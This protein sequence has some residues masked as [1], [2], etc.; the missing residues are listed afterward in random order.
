MGE[1]KY[2]DIG[3]KFGNIYHLGNM[4][5]LC[6]IICIHPHTPKKKEKKKVSEKG[7]YGAGI[8]LLNWEHRA[9]RFIGGEV[10]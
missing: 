1:A 3:A 2:E 6:H 4:I 7:E 9:D 10:S 5:R 8:W